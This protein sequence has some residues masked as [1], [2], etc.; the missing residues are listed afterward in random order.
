MEHKKPIQTKKQK[1]AKSKKAPQAQTQGAQGQ[2]QNKPSKKKEPIRL[3]IGSV[4]KKITKNLILSTLKS[5][6]KS[7][8]ISNFH[9]KR[10]PQAQNGYAF[11]E[12]NSLKT[13]IT[14]TKKPLKFKNFELYCQLSH[15]SLTIYREE[16][17]FRGFIKDLPK[18]IPD[19]LIHDFYSKMAKIESFYS[20]KDS[21]MNSKGYGFID[22]ANK[23]ELE[24]ISKKG[25]LNLFGSYV[26]VVPYTFK[27]KGEGGREEEYNNNEEEEE[28]EEE[29]NGA[30]REEEREEEGCFDGRVVEKF[31][32]VYEKKNKDFKKEK[33]E[34]K[35]EVNNIN[36]NKNFKKKSLLN[37]KKNKDFKREK[38]E[39][40]FEVNK[41]KNLKN[42]KK[43]SLLL[44]EKK[45]YRRNEN[46]KNL[47]PQKEQ[48]LQLNNNPTPPDTDFDMR[49]NQRKRIKNFEKLDKEEKVIKIWGKEKPLKL[50]LLA[51]KFLNEKKSN[52]RYNREK[53]SKGRS[54]RISELY[55]LTG[56]HYQANRENQETKSFY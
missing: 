47:T 18:D 15:K 37:E 36:K 9:I 49:F 1:P 2:N 54:L 41:N 32:F 12:T 24:K 13:A 7:F 40:K 19:R 26:Q 30:Y 35:F 20:I 27:E 55:H 53:R 8:K 25:N 44:N 17:N 31:N 38:N 45:N 42:L 4:P 56:G 6:T 33:N 11:F 22:F 48:E 43:K 50:V 52:Y 10:K 39:E 29:G 34:E 16:L 21:K 28:E 5:L 14:L 3:F 51:S 46:T 23:E